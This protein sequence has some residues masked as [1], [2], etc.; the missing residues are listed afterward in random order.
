MKRS[1][2]LLGVASSL[3]LFLGI[4]AALVVLVGSTGRAHEQVVRWDIVRFS[5][6]ANAGGEASA[7]A[8]NARRTQDET[9]TIT[10]TG[11]GTFEVPEEDE[12]GD[13]VTGGGTWTITTGAMTTIGSYEVTGVVRWTE[14]PGT[15]P[16]TLTDDIGNPADAR[17]GLVV[18]RIKYSDGDR[19]ILVVSCSFS[20]SLTPTLFEGITASKGFT[21]FWK[22][23]PASP[24]LFHVINEED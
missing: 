3:G 10:M 17:A 15:F 24:T 11:S 7:K 13:D 20:A 6:G 18:L 1:F 12:E 14:A 4:V 8:T 19:G 5:P 9:S 23:R 21:D 2:K 22:A 16:S